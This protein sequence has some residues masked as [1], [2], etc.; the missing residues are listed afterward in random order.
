MKVILISIGTRG[1]MESFLAIGGLLKEKECRVICASPEQFKKLAESANMEFRSL[2]SK[3]IEL[4]E[5][6]AGKAALGGGGSVMRK[7]Q[8][9]WER[10]ILK[11]KFTEPW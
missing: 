7:L 2:G 9:R 10:K 5:S 1:D 8:A 6:D 3:F 4:L 11:R